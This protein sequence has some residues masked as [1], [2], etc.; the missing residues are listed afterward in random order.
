MR[1]Q[2]EEGVGGDD[3]AGS[4]TPMRQ[5]PINWDVNEVGPDLLARRH[6]RL[7]QQTQSRVGGPDKSAE[8]GCASAYC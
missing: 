7:G 5:A 3:D 6:T 1:R 8:D 4:H 2:V